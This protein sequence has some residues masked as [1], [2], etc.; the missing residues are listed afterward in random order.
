MWLAMLRFF[1]KLHWKVFSLD[2]IDF[3]WVYGFGDMELAMWLRETDRTPFD[4]FHWCV[5]ENS[6]QYK[7]HQEWMFV[8]SQRRGKH[9]W[10]F[11][12]LRI[13]NFIY[14]IFFLHPLI[15]GMLDQ[16]WP[17]LISTSLAIV[18]ECICSRIIKV[19]VT[20]LSKRKFKAE[21]C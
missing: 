4:Y 11:G 15:L 10:T 14:F 17:R 21:S 3:C 13:F 6:L 18:A 7:T 5:L 9:F 19:S 16:C 2:L 1:W 8:D 12:G 20:K